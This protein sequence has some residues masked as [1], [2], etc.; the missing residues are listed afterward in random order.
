[1]SNPFL[2]ATAPEF[3]AWVLDV[4]PAI[5]KASLDTAIEM[6]AYLTEHA[7]RFYAYSEM[8]VSAARLL[9]DLSP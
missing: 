5:S 3:P 2:P 9:A 8:D 1:M 6:E 4:P 7:R